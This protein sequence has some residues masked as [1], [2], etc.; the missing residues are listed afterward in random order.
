M[1]RF[2]VN[3]PVQSDQPTITVEVDATHPLPP[4]RHRYQLAVTD[5]SGNVSA[6]DTVVVIVADRQRPTAVL[7]GPAVVDFGKGFVLSGQKSF[8]IGGR[9]VSYTFTYLGPS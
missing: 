1:P 2:D 8:D 5:D 7:E 6:P 3:V 4:G 9:I